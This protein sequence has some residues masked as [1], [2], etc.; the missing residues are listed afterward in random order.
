MTYHDRVDVPLMNLKCFFRA[1]HL[2]RD[3]TQ[4]V[5]IPPIQINLSP[6]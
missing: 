5:K 3:P 4:G 6:L 1:G 2:G